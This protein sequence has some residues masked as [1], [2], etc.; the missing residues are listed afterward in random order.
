MATPIPVPAFPVSSFR[1]HR[2]DEDDPTPTGPKP[3][4]P[5]RDPSPKESALLM[6]MRQRCVDFTFAGVAA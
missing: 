2:S 6:E 3:S 5:P 1:P 4:A